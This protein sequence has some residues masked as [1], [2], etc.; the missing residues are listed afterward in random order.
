MNVRG[1]NKAKEENSQRRNPQQKPREKNSEA[2]VVGIHGPRDAQRKA[3]GLEQIYGGPPDQYPGEYGG[4]HE[5]PIS[6]DDG[7]FG[8]LRG[9][10]CAA[11]KPERERHWNHQ[12]Q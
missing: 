12:Q 2:V 11:S 1:K 5:S 9:F 4:E 3:I 8:F 10:A 7:W 6:E